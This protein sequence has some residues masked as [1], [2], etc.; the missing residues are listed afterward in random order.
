MLVIDLVTSVDFTYMESKAQAHEVL[1]SPNGISIVDYE[2]K[3]EKA[4]K[5]LNQEWIERYFKMEE[6]DHKAL[7]H[8][9]EYIL[10]KGGHI[11]VALDEDVPVG[12][13]A[14]IK[15]KDH[16]FELAKMAVSPNAQGKGVGF[17]LGN[18]AIAQARQ[19]GAT[20]LYL[21]S[22]TILKPA[23][24]LYHKLGFQ[25]MTGYTSPYE[26]CDIQMQRQL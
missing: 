4:F 26:R 9:Q 25:E 15:M 12:V 11:F 16:R 13:C 6:S 1:S 5:Q 18:A 17:M 10:N 3:Y 23:I 19:L 2:P 7:D 14:L 20:S 24:A 8:P 21:E 22:N